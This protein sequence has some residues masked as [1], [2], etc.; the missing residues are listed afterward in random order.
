MSTPSRAVT[1]N[2]RD[3]I[4]EFIDD[5]PKRA[6]KLLWLFVQHDPATP[7]GCANR[8]DSIRYAYSLTEDSDAGLRKKVKAFAASLV[9]LMCCSLYLVF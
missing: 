7:A 3:I 2:R 1:Y 5:D 9:A 8:D 4:A 6:E